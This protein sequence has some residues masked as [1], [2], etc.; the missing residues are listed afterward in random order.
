MGY[1]VQSRQINSDGWLPQ[2]RERW[3]WCGWAEAH[4]SSPPGNSQESFTGIPLAFWGEHPN[5][6]ALEMERWSTFWPGPILASVYAVSCSSDLTSTPGWSLFTLPSRKTFRRLLSCLNVSLSKSMLIWEFRGMVSFVLEMVTQLGWKPW[7]K[8]WI[9]FGCWMGLSFAWCVKIVWK[10]ATFK[11]Q[12]FWAF[13]TNGNVWSNTREL[14]IS[15]D[16]IGGASESIMTAAKGQIPCRVWPW[17]KRKLLHWK[18]T[19]QRKW[20]II[21]H[22]TILLMEEILHQ[23]IGSMVFAWFCR[24]FPTLLVGTSKLLHFAGCTLWVFERTWPAT[25]LNGLRHPGVT[26]VSRTGPAGHGT[27]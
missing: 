26:L 18:E 27:V 25:T 20:T 19:F 4:S 12:D 2:K 11:H 16:Y 5:V 17:G 8:S 15:K 22:L 14:G 1:T 3:G 9:C 24:H 13:S 23:L 7:L 6:L 10:P 21:C